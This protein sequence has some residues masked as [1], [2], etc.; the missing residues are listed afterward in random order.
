MKDNWNE[1]MGDV[2]ASDVIEAAQNANVTV[3]DWLHTMYLK[4]HQDAI[5]PDVQ[6][7]FDDLAEQIVKDAR[8]KEYDR[9][10]E[11]GYSWAEQVANI[12]KWE[13]SMT[14]QAVDLAI[15]EGDTTNWLEAD[16]SSDYVDGF[17]AGVWNAYQVNHQ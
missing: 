1:V 13:D 17:H 6:I 2:K 11:A 3:A 4:M 14:R 7:D 15:S 16:A 12:S 9:G 10:T 8:Y 5:D